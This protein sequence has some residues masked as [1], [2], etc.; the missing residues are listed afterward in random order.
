MACVS[1]LRGEQDRQMAGAFA[2]P[3]GA[4][5]RARLEPL[6]GRTLI[7]LHGLDDEVLADELV[8]VLGI[9]DRGLEQLA[10]IARDRTRRDSEDSSRILDRL[11]AELVADQPRL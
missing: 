1:V 8:V 7:S 11:A 6:D 10:P 3:R 9:G 5:L 2:D 4:P